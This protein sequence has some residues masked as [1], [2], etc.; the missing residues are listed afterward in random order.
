MSLHRKKWSNKEK[1]ETLLYVEKNGV[2]KTSRECNLFEKKRQ[3]RLVKITI[4]MIVKNI[5]TL[6]LILLTNLCYCQSSKVRLLSEIQ[7]NPESTLCIDYDR[8]ILIDSFPNSGILRY[9]IS[10]EYDTIHLENRTK[11][12]FDNQSE[13]LLNISK[14]MECFRSIGLAKY[15]YDSLKTKKNDFIPVNN[16]IIH[17]KEHNNTKYLI[18]QDSSKWCFNF[19]IEGDD[20]TYM[21]HLGDMSDGLLY[22]DFMLLD[23]TGN[24]AP[25]I[26][27]FKH[28]LIGPNELTYIQVYSVNKE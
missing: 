26:F 5:F 18:T 22:A 17:F 12:E 16:T 25:E 24:I 3:K 6:L 11:I 23:F 20:G 13:D 19:I 8:I 9:Y 14:Y 27:V 7:A 10:D 15:K 2:S 1:E 21:N 28:I 4:P